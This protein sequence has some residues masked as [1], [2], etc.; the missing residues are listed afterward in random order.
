[1]RIGVAIPCF[2]KHIDYCYKLLDSINVQT[3]L[4]DQVI[5]SCSSS[6]PEDFVKRE[7]K[8]PLTIITSEERKNASQNRNIA[9]SNL[10]T[11]IISFIDGDDIMHPQ[12]LEVIE[13]AF[14]QNVHAV[15]HSFFENDECNQPFPNVIPC[16]IQINRLERAAYTKCIHFTN[17][18]ITKKSWSRIHQAQVSLLRIIFEQVKFKEGSEFEL[19]ADSEFCYDVFGLPNISSAYIPKPLSKYVQS[20]TCFP[21]KN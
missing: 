8:F 2:I 19:C 20:Y 15:L 14:K 16:D 21:G 12:R 1:M 18:D 7:Y 10:D 5:V 13:N 9:A 6:K 3:R 4:P 17:K 11:D